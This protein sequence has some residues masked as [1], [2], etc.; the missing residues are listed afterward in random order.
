M[1]HWRNSRQRVDLRGRDINDRRRL[2][3][4]DGETVLFFQIEGFGQEWSASLPGSSWSSSS[5]STVRQIT[6]K[7]MIRRTLA[8]RVRMMSMGVLKGFDGGEVDHACADNENGDVYH[9]CV[10]FWQGV[11]F[12]LP[13]ILN[14]ECDQNNQQSQFPVNP[15]GF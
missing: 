2:F 5:S 14:A 7:P 15:L 11:F 4:P 12:Y 6:K 13:A 9:H 8:T 10:F 3:F 1:N